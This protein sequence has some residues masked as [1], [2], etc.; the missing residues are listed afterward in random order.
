MTVRVGVIDSGWD[1]RLRDPRVE[2]GWGFCAEARP[3]EPLL[4]ADARDFV[5]HGTQC[6]RIILDVAKD[7]RVI[8]LRVFIGRL[9]T[10]TAVLCA[11]LE[12]AE[13]Q[14]LDV[15]NLSLATS[16]P[17]AMVP[18]YR[19][20][21]RLHDL[22]TMIVAAADNR[23]GGGYP[24]AFADVIGVDLGRHAAR[25]SE[26]GAA[27]REP[28]D[29]VLGASP[30]PIIDADGLRDQVLRRNSYAAAYVSGWV[31][32]IVSEHGPLPLE[33]V[34]RRL[35]DRLSVDPIARMAPT[36]GR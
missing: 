4:T 11:A 30:E 1:P 12:W 2:V 8:P 21:E 13:A 22:G 23:D 15:V 20:C 27:E 10:S 28:M 24:A 34:R 19:R 14:R 29:V 36:P 3:Y 35:R 9:E 31:A 25:E 7:V 26:S 18:L 17:D 5:G 32:S 33:A 6:A 16:E